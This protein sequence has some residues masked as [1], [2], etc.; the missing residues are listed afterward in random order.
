MVGEQHMYNTTEQFME[1]MQEFFP[2]TKERYNESV[3]EYGEVRVTIIIEDV[4]MPEIIRLLSADENSPFLEEIFQYIEEIVSDNNDHL[5]DILSVTMFEILGNDKK[6]LKTAL[7]YM[8]TKTTMLQLEANKALG[9][10]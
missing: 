8:G 2:V 5:I 1:K 9:R 7:R 4:F 10:L 3:A 6:I